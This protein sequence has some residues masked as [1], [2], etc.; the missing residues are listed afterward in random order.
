M[1]VGLD[2]HQCELR[3]ATAHA[4][5]E[6]CPPAALRDAWA[7]PHGLSRRR[8]R[9]LAE[10]GLTSVTLPTELGGLGGTEVDLV[11]LLEEVGYV[12]LP[13]PVADAAVAASLLA[14]VAPQSADVVLAGLADGSTVLTL[15]VPSHPYVDHATAADAV[16]LATSDAVHL[17]EPGVSSWE[18]HVSVD[19]GRR[20]ARWVGPLPPPRATDAGPAIDRAIQRATLASAAMLV[21]LGRRSVDLGVAYAR[22]RHQFGRPIGSYQALRHR[23]A[24]DWTALEFARPLV[25]RAAWSLA[26]DAPDAHL[27]VSMAKAAAGDAAGGAARTAVQVHGAMGYTFECDVQLYLKRTLALA[28]AHGDARHHR[29]RVAAVLAERDIEALP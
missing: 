28:S 17:I 16:V 20:L 24:D 21:G 14:E 8:W 25:W 3:D 11:P 10:L 4:L 12:A 1:Y 19:G 23:L 27:H 26:H 29:R 18:E 7:D 13:E 5:G 2:P 6:L 22:E 9:R 15:G